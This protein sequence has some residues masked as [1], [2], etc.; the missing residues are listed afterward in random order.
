MLDGSEN[1]IDSM[2]FENPLMIHRFIEQRPDYEALCT[3]VVYILKKRFK[4][5]EIVVAD[6]PSRAKTLKS[7]LEKIRRKKYEDPMKNIQDFAGIRVVCLYARDVDRIEAI[8]HDEF[9]MLEKVDKREE[10]GADQFGYLAR[11]Y[12]AKLKLE[13]SGARYEDLKDLVFELQVRTILQDAW[14]IIDHHLVYKHET[15]VPVHLKRKLRIIA[16]LFENADDQFNQIYQEINE[17]IIEPSASSQREIEQFL[18][19]KLDLDSFLVY[20]PWKFNDVPIQEGLDDAKNVFELINK[21]KYT[22]LQQLDEAVQLTNQDKAEIARLLREQGR[23][24]QNNA[25]YRTYLALAISDE[26]FRKRHRF[27]SKWEKFIEERI[28]KH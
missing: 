28:V 10:M 12:I 23:E 1:D 25:A 4:Q 24:G 9:E 14:A 17:Y 27:G 5:L 3:E 2:W 11:H 16:G 7:F 22:T 8:V 26:D 15:E 13:T 20:L 21:N 18:Q 19:R 6:V